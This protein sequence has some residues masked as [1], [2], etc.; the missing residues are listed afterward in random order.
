MSFMFGI[1]PRAY[2]NELSLRPRLPD[3]WNEISVENVAVGLGEHAN[4][5]GF[6]ISLSETTDVYRL[7]LAQPGWTVRMDLPN[8]ANAEITLDRAKVLPVV[9]QDNGAVILEIQ[10]AGKHEV[11]VIR[12]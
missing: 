7:E 8:A 1:R 10:N 5:L 2:W 4:R 3:D 11:L 6:S 9:V 12:A